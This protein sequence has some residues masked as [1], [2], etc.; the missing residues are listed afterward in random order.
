MVHRCADLIR[1]QNSQQCTTEEIADEY[2]LHFLI[3]QNMYECFN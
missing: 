3:Q 2:V 1:I